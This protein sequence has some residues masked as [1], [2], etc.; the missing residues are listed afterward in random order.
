MSE[1]FA[2]RALSGINLLLPIILFIAKNKT[3]PANRVF[4]RDTKICRWT[5]ELVLNKITVIIDIKTKI[6]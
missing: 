3:K 2:P 5:N 1:L 4:M 6:Q